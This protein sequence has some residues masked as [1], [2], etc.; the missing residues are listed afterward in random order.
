MT[1]A[2]V[3]NTDATAYLPPPPSTSTPDAKAA[4]VA[5][6]QAADPHAAGTPR[7]PSDFQSEL[8]LQQTGAQDTQ[9]A[10]PPKG[11]LAKS[12]SGKAGKKRSTPNGVNLAAVTPAQ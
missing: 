10:V 9:P 11:G 4:G 3:Q 1:A 8:A 2:G 5:G 6:K 7:E 12:G